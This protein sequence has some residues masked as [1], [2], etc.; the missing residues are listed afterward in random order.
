[1]QTSKNGIDEMNADN[2]HGAWYDAQRLS[3]ALFTGNNELAKKI[4]ANA[5]NRIEKQINEEGF[6]P[7]ELER[8]IS[9]HYSTFVLEAFF[10]IALMAEETGVDLWNYT[11][12]SGRS[13]KQAFNALKPYLI[14]EKEWDGKQIKPFEFE[15]GY[16]L[17]MAAQH[18]LGCKDCLTHVQTIAGE[19]AARLRLN[20][21]Y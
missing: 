17:L 20:L 3:M 9:L 13:L 1:M 4:V 15:E 5:Q 6:F 11:T 8:T 12:P 16:F 21:L 14:K 19:K 2:N 10:D 7:K 18:H